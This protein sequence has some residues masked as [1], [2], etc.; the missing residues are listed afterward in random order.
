M[1]LM[2]IGDFAGESG[3]SAKALRLYDELGLLT[4][5]EV[6]PFNGYRRYAPAQLPRARLVA[7][8]RLVGMPLA[9]IRQVILLPDEAA[10]V[11]IEAYW[12]QAEADHA[13]RRTT[14]VGLV[15]RMH[16]RK[17]PMN[18][19]HPTH[20]ELTA[21]AAH[22]HRQGARRSQQ[23]AVLTGAG[24]FA[25]AD[26][27]GNHDD[28]SSR[29]L[30]TLVGLED[31]HTT[32]PAAEI[33]AAVARAAAAVLEEVA[34][35]DGTT[36]TALW[37]HQGSAITAHVGDARIHLVRDGTVRRL[38]RDHTMVAELVAE[39]RLNEEEAAAHPKRMLINRAL[40]P[41]APSVPDI[42]L[43]TVRPGDRLVLTTDGVHSVL[44]AAELDEMLV[45]PGDPDT[46]AARI[47]AAVEDAGA[48]DNHTVVVI[49]ISE[50]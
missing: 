7:G 45:A 44:Q 42:G 34:E 48:P 26:G 29:A 10:A 22:R 46:V 12:R 25:V 18:T 30:E 40:A 49:A 32:D 16:E 19:T 47:S 50:G 14:L 2:N 13:S 33:E 3:L 20:P 23:D 36:L 15:A 4:P 37:L 31:C 24:L 27:F 28:V 17:T 8:L 38:T 43:T 9:R 21:S 11:E 1:A 39:G 35:S 41:G 5:A 6:D